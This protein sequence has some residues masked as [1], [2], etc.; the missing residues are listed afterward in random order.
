MAALVTP[1]PA[2]TASRDSEVTEDDKT[3]LGFANL[4]EELSLAL[5][6][7]NEMTWKRKDVRQTVVY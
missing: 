4:D 7:G 5:R 3:N 1:D 2:S 6:A